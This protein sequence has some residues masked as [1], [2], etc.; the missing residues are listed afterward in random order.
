VRD[1]RRRRHLVDRDLVVVSI[2]EDLDRGLEE[3]LAALAG[4]LRCQGTLADGPT[5][6]LG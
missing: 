2:A 1:A 4:A 6:A 5:L 3:L